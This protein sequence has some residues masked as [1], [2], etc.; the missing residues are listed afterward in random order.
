M[1][2]YRDNKLLPTLSYSGKELQSR[3]DQLKNGRQNGR[4]LLLIAKVA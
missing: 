2:R 4:Y 1:L 3:I